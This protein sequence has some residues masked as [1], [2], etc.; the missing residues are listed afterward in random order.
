MKK[1]N[2]KRS[3]FSWRASKLLLLT[4]FAVL[5]GASPAWAGSITE[6]FESVTIDA[7]DK[8]KLSNGWFIKG[9]TNIVTKNVTNSSYWSN[10]MPDGFDYV[11]LGTGGSYNI[12][13]NSTNTAFGQY[14]NGCTSY[15]IIPT[16]LTGKIKFYAG[17]IRTSN[18]NVK[19][20]RVSYNSD[21]KEYS[22]GT[23]ITTIYPAARSSSTTRPNWLAAK[24]E[25]DLGSEHTMVAFLLNGTAIDEIEAEE[26]VFTPYVEPATLSAIV[27][28]NTA[29]VSWT[30]GATEEALTGWN[31]EYKKTTEDTWTEVH[32]IG[33]STLSNTI[34]NLEVGYSYD[35]RV[36]A[37]YGENESVWK[38]T[39]FSLVYTTPAP[40]SVDGDGI[41]NVAYGTG[42]EVV[43]YNTSKSPYYQNN[44]AQIGAVT[45]G[46]EATVAITFSTGYTYG[47]VVWVDWNQNYEFEDS[48]IV[49]A[50]ECT[51]AKPN[52]LN[53]VFTVPAQ[54][55]AGNYRMRICAADSYYDSH[56]TMATA[57]GA[58]ATPTGSYCVAQD[59][60]L[61]VKEAAAYAMSV[62]ETAIAFG[63]VK[64]TTT[65]TFTI[66]NDGD[67]ALTGV[68]VISSD[69]EIFT[70][71]ETG[72]DIAAAGSKEITVTFIKGVAGDYE[73]TITVSQANV[74]TNKVINVTATYE[75][76][77]SATMA[78]TLGE[79]A[80][81]AT[82][83]FGNVGKQATKTFTV[84]ND[85]DQTLNI[86]SIVS[87][88]TTDF[89]VSPSSL[90][91]DGHSSKTF[92]VTFVY[93]NEN[94]V[95]NTEKTANITVTASNEGI[96]PVVFAVTG[97]RI[98]QWSEDFS[99][100]V[101]PEG[102]NAES[103]W[104]FEDGVAHGAYN[105]SNNRTKALTTPLLTVTGTTDVLT[106]KAK[107]TSTYVSIKIK[108]S[109]DGGA[110]TD[111]KTENLADNMSGFETYTITGLGA[112]D[113]K[114]Q[115]MND[116]YD[117]DD[118]EG[119][120]LN[121]NDPTLFVSSDA[122]GNT[123][124]ASG[125]AKDFG[126]ASTAQ[127]ATY[128]IKN[129]GTGTLTIN[130]ISNVDGF[131]ATTANDAMTVAKDADPLALTITMNVA[132][133]GAKNGTFTI[134]TDGGTFTI[135]VSGYVVGSKNLIDFTANEAT[136][137]T[138]WKRGNWSVTNGVAIST[139]AST[140]ETRN[141][142][143]AAGENLLVD[144][145]G[146]SANETK[147]FAYS[148]STDNGTNWSDANTL[149]EASGYGIIDDQVLTIS[150]IADA[151]AERTV[152][153]RFIGQNLGIKHIYGFTAVTEPIM[154]TTAADIAFGMQTAESTEQTFT[155][156]NEGNATLEGL[157]VT[158]GKTG[159]DAEYSIALYDGEDAFAGTELATGKT[160]TVKVKQLFDIDNTGSK[161]DVLTIAATGQEPVAI[162]L[163]GATRDGSKLYVT[164]DNEFPMPSGWQLGTNWNVNSY[165]K[166]LYHTNSTNSA[167]RTTPLT[168]V[169]G[170]KMTFKAKKY[171]SGNAYL[172]I[173]YSDD[174]GITWNDA[175]FTPV[176]TSAS[177][178]DENELTSIP[179][180]TVVLE[181]VGN[182]VQIDDIYGFAEANAPMIEFATSEE[183]NND[184]KY[185]FG[186]ALQEA[187]ANKVYTLTN[188]GT[189]NLVST[190]AATGDVTFVLASEN[191]ELSNE[192]KTVTLEA[193]ESATIT[194]SLNF[195]A[196]EI[197]EKTGTITITSNAPVAAKTFDFIARVID[198]STLNEELASLPEGWYNG[199][200]TIDGTAHVYTGVDK[201]LITELYGAETN[202]NVLSFDAKVQ[203]GND[204]TELKVYTSSDRK[205]WSDP[206][207]FTLK[208]D[209]QNF[210]LDALADGNYYVKFESLNASIDN[211]SGLKKLT[212]PEH[213][214]YASATTFPSTTLIP[215][216][217]NGVTASATVYSLRA[218][219]TGVYAKL[220][221]DE[222]EIATA[223][224]QDISK[225][226]S[227]T[228][229]FT[230][231]VPATEK[232][233]AAK[234]VVYYSDNSVAW[235]TATTDVVVSHTRTLQ[236]TDFARTSDATA[237]ANGDNQFTST[238][239]VTVKN[240]GTVNYNAANVSVSITDAE[241]NVIG[242]N[243]T[244]W[245]LANSQ[246]VFI[247][248]GEYTNDGA[249]L[250]IWRYNTD[251][252]GEWGLF[253]KINDNLYS[254]ERNG[255]TNFNIVRLKK[256]GDD[257]YNSENGGLNWDNKYNQSTD[258]KNTD[259]N[260]FTFKGWDDKDGEN[261]H[262]FT[263]GTMS[264]LPINA[265]TTFAVSLTTSALE[266]GL[267]TFKAKENMSNTVSTASATVTV[268]AAAPK[269][270]LY[271]DATPVNDGDDVQFGIVKGDTKDF[272]FTIR[273]EGNKMME[274]PEMAVP[275]GFEA[276]YVP[277][278]GDVSEWMLFFYKDG[279][280]DADQGSFKATA[281]EN[282]YI[283]ENVNVPAS[284]INFAVHKK[285]GN[286]WTDIY[287]YSDEGGWLDATAK[288][289]KLATATNASGWM[290]IAAGNYDF[291]WNATDL[292]LMAK[293][294]GAI[295]A[296]E[297]Q[298][299]NVTLKAEQGKVNG[300]LVFTYK[301]DGSTNNTF[302]LALSGRSVA[303]DTWVEEFTTEIP[304]SWTNN[305]WEW[306]SD[307][308]AAYNTYSAGKT[309][310]TP[311]LAAENGE[312]LTFDLYFPYSGYQMKVQYSTDK[313]NWTEVATYTSTSNGQTIE[314]SFTAPAEGNYY[315]L[316]GDNNSNSKYAYVDNFVG[317]QL[318]IPEHDMEIAA[319]AVP[320][321]GKQY[322]TYTATVSLKENAG[323]DEAITA[324][325]FVNGE[326]VNADVDVTQADKNATTVVTL[327]WEPQAVID[328]AVKAYV[329]VSYDGGELTTEEVDLT[330][331]EVYTL[332]EE[333]SA[334]TIEAVTDE[335]VLLKRTFAEGWNTVCLPF[336][337][338]DVEA[339]FGIGAKA[340]NFTSYTNGTL[341]FATVATLDASYP[342]IVYVP[343]AITEA[344][345]LS[346]ITISS[347]TDEGWHVTSNEAT[348]QGTY[349]PIAAPGMEGLWG[350]TNAAKIA[351]GTD[352][353]SM[354]GFRA[355]F[356][357]PEGA[358]ARLSFFDETTGIRTV[359][360]EQLIMNSSVYNMNGQKV[361]KAKKGLYIINGK[362]QVIK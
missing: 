303:A 68:S 238:F 283:L 43:N 215:E 233:Y 154:T 330:V 35:V 311:R 57:T 46:S 198:A 29:E 301:V 120:K 90:E 205:T 276:S 163:S 84:T 316:F 69:S 32:S 86:T 226:A 191:G 24:Q 129:T 152:L 245:N 228:F 44:S 308:K 94:P 21:T 18:T 5:V 182:N 110:F 322:N 204:D 309:L 337:I 170:E 146:S 174:G 3:Q 212:A 25:V 13:A 31:L 98:E 354:K 127:T 343:A 249:V 300:D 150:D 250:A 107:S 256:E 66:V 92:T 197:G 11:I 312:E 53:A 148:Y 185:D 52:T 117:L 89:T 159:E 221:F 93:P 193:G 112:G 278:D 126:W 167:L 39:S 263:Y 96:D 313:T 83:A 244:T 358:E 292:T 213:D 81:G 187:P 103:Y 297:S 136:I 134:T 351:K 325:L 22:I 168:V 321:T 142:T 76:P 184:N 17:G 359:Y 79:E 207:I 37:I 318:N 188:R 41:T 259:G 355:Y 109:K 239:N 271:Q 335:T 344:K 85:G 274:K 282:K 30:A 65:K 186:Q 362:K 295:L 275:T 155:I 108:Y 269:F 261:K 299:V 357:L 49:F 72:F 162:N 179:A 6:D 64:N 132:N 340:Y 101:Q 289:T 4:L 342:Y 178:Y 70:V 217:E 247:N 135:P 258:M 14:N 324:K 19:L 181:F 341:N 1:S 169:E 173:R 62:S 268:N 36:S 20:Y 45:A 23:L 219:E 199:G 190:V 220:F 315:L 160:I 56:K 280:V 361:E 189:A 118:F 55:A 113:Y 210:K 339:F 128:Y 119:F 130:S 306:N 314:G 246:T 16:E 350:V 194:V 287:G 80:V 153:I 333:T 156:S 349:A 133:E 27:T 307:R 140:M 251:S 42:A 95:L 293:P 111:L 241:G 183:M 310:M 131:T 50:G 143:V 230:A 201:T 231:N 75:A 15:L 58:N 177:K 329:K 196:E 33:A 47:T 151:E 223:D 88:N 77:S 304:A 285:N 284:G 229:N 139:S 266:G 114:F 236:I 97:T 203:S 60:T 320:T 147:S 166:Y 296:G 180:G 158:L 257:G 78:V 171:G 290:T 165:G 360:S 214:L 73:E 348:F 326:D 157:S 252:D 99:G 200:W 328:E 192:N 67:N 125:T 87:N 242:E 279:T 9:G 28:G 59:Y 235:E 2:L 248:P 265:S 209:P 172:A 338:S 34:N 336:T 323:K 346:N 332:D 115:F 124:V 232:T 104:T 91:I 264:E 218:D 54:Q 260:F 123:E 347:T 222:A 227:K 291:I 302:T 144:I 8:T 121:A 262:W 10:N 225:D 208:K 352:Q 216:T 138:G 243:T 305:G 272:T 102:W 164:F 63:T 61:K 288:A 175:T 224:A 319:S 122:A 12:G 234:I 286:D 82:V 334:S 116:N 277:A 145:K 105:Y 137:P 211:L 327:T 202:K 176:I 331:T 51:S 74:A 353:A 161:S 149:L 40:T 253:T 294:A 345:K 267:F 254:A 281:T 141:F 206:T 317:F 38:S 100:N 273:N 48:E 270:A 356:V 298:D 195:N 106:Y 26:Y 240:T 255:K 7:N 71:S 237:D